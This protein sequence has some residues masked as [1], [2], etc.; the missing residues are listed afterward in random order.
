[1]KTGGCGLTRQE[2]P[3]TGKSD[4]ERS[5][6]LC[7]RGIRPAAHAFPTRRAVRRVMDAGRGS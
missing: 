4:R 7:D 1:M 6:L 3:V 2:R 5:R